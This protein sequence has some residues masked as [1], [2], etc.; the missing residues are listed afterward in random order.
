MKLLEERISQDGV[1]I[2]NDILKVDSFINHQIDINL[3]NAFAD[4]V[5]NYFKDKPVD[6]ILTIETSGIASCLHF[7]IL[8][9]NH[10]SFL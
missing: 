4:E 7:L 3:I 8:M 2:N 5:K 10:H 9:I 1:V 6:K